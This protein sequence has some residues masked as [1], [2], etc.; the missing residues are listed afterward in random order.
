MAGRLSLWTSRTSWQSSKS[1]RK[2]LFDELSVAKSRLC[3]LPRQATPA[4]AIATQLP[5]SLQYAFDCIRLKFVHRRDT[6]SYV[7][8]SY[9]AL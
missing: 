6:V 1:L 4:A 7:G 9:T 5:T 2:P 3:R 8:P